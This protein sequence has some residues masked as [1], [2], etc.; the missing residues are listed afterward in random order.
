M[1]DNLLPELLRLHD[2]IKIYTLHTVIPLNVLG[3]PKNPLN[4]EKHLI[5]TY[6]L[7][8]PM[9][10]HKCTQTHREIFLDSVILK[11]SLNL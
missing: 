4:K 8:A 5:K 2:F 6:P 11:S 10:A 9:Y 1:R 7:P 3:V